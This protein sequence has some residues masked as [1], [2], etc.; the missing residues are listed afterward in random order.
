MQREESSARL[1]LDN[2]WAAADSGFPGIASPMLLL[3]AE[4]VETV[5]VQLVLVEADDAH[6][7]G[8][9]DDDAEESSWCNRRYC[10]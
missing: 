3:L 1:V 5:I 10:L 2:V 4:E 9:L 6:D 8:M 7:D